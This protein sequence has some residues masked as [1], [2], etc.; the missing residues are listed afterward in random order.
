MWSAGKHSA[1][2]FSLDDK[3]RLARG[4]PRVDKHVYARENGW[5]IEAL[6]VLGGLTKDA[7][8]IAEAERA[9]RWIVA[10][11]SL[12]GG[13]FRHGER[14]AAGPYMGDTL[15]MGRAFAALH[16]ATGKKEW[17]DRSAGAAKFIEAR[18]ATKAGYVTA[19]GGTR[20]REENVQ[21]ARWFAR[22]AAATGNGE[23]G[24]MRERALRYVATPEIAGLRPAASVLLAAA[25]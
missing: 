4:V 21:A 22:L 7:E 20:L 2:Y 6:A 25:E 14:D 18:F 12:A 13:G 10:N 1:E 15:A 9:A 3:G 8:T 16:A 23:Y 17:L 19:P 11:R 24:K 5:M